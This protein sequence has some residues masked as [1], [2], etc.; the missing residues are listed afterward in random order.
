[1]NLLESALAYREAGL[2]VLPAFLEKKRPAL[3]TWKYF[4]NKLPNQSVVKIWF[5][6]P[7]NKALC[8]VC[9]RISGNLEMIDFDNN[10]ELFPAFMARLKHEDRILADCLVIE[11]SQTRA[12]RHIIYRCES[13]VQGNLILNQRPGDKKMI[14]LIETRGEGG[15]FLCAP[16]PGYE[17]LQGSL[18]KLIVITADERELLLTI[19]REVEL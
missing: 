17:V 4:R 12:N 6:D 5:H 15:L 7:H 18:T 8:I 10:G 14:R 9:G 11:S 2:C 3:G 19:A 1:M 16:S 13:P